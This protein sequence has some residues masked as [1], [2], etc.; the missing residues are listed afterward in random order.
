MVPFS[1]DTVNA[2]RVVHVK[3]AVEFPPFVSVRG[4]RSID[5]RLP[6]GNYR[7]CRDASKEREVT[8]GD[9]SVMVASVATA[10]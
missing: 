3:A 7:G 10:G 6:S 4:C 9:L 5:S 2:P 8:G 1:G